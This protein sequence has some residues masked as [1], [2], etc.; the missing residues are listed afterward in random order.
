MDEPESKSPE[1]FHG[2]VSNARG[3]DRGNQE[4]E[5]RKRTTDPGWR[6]TGG[7]SE[8]EDHRKRLYYQRSDQKFE[9]A[10]DRAWNKHLHSGAEVKEGSV[11]LMTKVI[12]KRAVHA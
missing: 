10:G 4:E 8:Y 12:P 7:R 9:R 2:H 1:Q 3:G 11:C 5:A 6:K